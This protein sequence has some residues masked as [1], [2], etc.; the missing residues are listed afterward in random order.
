MFGCDDNTSSLKI[1]I[2]KKTKKKDAAV[3]RLENLG[4]CGRGQLF[5]GL[6]SPFLVGNVLKS[7]F[8]PVLEQEDGIQEDVVYLE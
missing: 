7:H 5:E 6:P 8:F 4:K 2:C 1:K 3:V